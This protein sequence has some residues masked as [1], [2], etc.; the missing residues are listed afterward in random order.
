MRWN[1]QPIPLEVARRVGWHPSTDMVG[2]GVYGGVVKRDSTGKILVGDEWPEDNCAPPAHNPVSSS[3]PYL[4][5]SK[6][7]PA[8][9]GYSVISTLII[10]GNASRL[11][12]L[13]NSID[14][15]T[16]RR[17]LAN[18]VMTGG[19]RPLHMCGM[20]YGADA[21]ELVK[22]LIKHG[23][24]VNAKDNYSMTPIDRL[25]SNAVTGASI[26]KKHGAV[27]GFMLSPELPDWQSDDFVF[28]NPVG[29]A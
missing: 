22:V 5:Y 1:D 26:L 19:A 17:S 14:S 16:D 6:Y 15:E 9:R 29:E 4:D 13:F 7:T 2:A 8:N 23:A 18:L 25:G 27:S 12:A 10:D 20:S 28:T 21:A 3:G 24:D 11:D